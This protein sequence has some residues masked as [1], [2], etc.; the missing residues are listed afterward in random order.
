MVRDSAGVRIVEYAG[1]PDPEAPFALTPEPVYRHGGTA[2]EYSFGFIGLGRLFADGRAALTDDAN[3]EVVLLTPDGASHSLLAV[4]GQG[5]GEVGYVIGMYTL[6]RDSLVVLDRSNSRYNLFVNGSLARTESLA[7]LQRNTSLWPQG[8]DATGGFLAATSSYRSGFE[9]EWLQ[10]HMAR[11]N[12]ETG[13]IDTVASYDFI[14]G[15]GNPARGFGSVAVAAG[16][17][18]YTR[19]DKPEVTWLAAGGMVEQTLRW[20]AEPEHL[21]EEHLEPLE[22]SLREGNRFANPQAPAEV[23]ESMTQEDMARFRAD[24]GQPLPLFRSP[25]GDVEGRVWLPTHVPGGPREGSPPYA[26]I[27]PDGEWLGRVDAPPGLRILD[28]AHGLVLGVLKDDMDVESV[29]VYELISR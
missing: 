14:P 23:I 12:L 18:V 13:V 21:T 24:L 16:R 27:S 3:S 25:F 11:F 29:V 26:A 1:V 22:A 15:P 8:I 19:S 7:D 20:Q 10:G 4:A 17:F 6:G 5:P 28:V 9:E 2:G